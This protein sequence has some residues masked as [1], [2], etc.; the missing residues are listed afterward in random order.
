MVAYSVV[1]VCVCVCVLRTGVV[2]CDDMHIFASV[3][4]ALYRLNSRDPEKP[5]NTRSTTN[6][7]QRQLI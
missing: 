1:H 2:V 4:D 5:A 3:K 7:A 6:K